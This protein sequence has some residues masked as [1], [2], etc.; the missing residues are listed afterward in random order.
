MALNEYQTD[1]FNAYARNPETWLLAARRHLAVAEVLMDR[2]AALTLKQ[3]RPFEEFS[4][5]FYA[6]FFHAG[7]A[8]ENATKAVLV[9]RD[10]SIVSN[11]SLD[12]RKLGGK[13]GHGSLALVCSVLND[14]SDSERRLLVKLQEYV[15]WAGKYTVPMSGKF[16]YD[17]EI[18]DIMRF[19]P[20]DE[21][22]TLRSLIMRL[23][24]QVVRAQ[25]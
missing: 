23:F 13:G 6:A 12:R 18:V 16:L 17:Q 4:G 7:V 21:R 1:D 19:S 25:A 11:G 20:A 22:E 24:A 15:V 9:S 8:V 2:V 5:C 3:S 14:L 10:P